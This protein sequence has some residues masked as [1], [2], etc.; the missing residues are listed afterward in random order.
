MTVSSTLQANVSLEEVF[1]GAR[2][3][4]CI[5]DRDGRLVYANPALERI[6]GYSPSELVE[7][8]HTYHP[9]GDTWED[10]GVVLA[11]SLC[12]SSSVFEKGGRSEVRRTHIT[13]KDGREIWIEAT[14]APVQDSDGNLQSILCFVRELGDADTRSAAATQP[15]ASGVSSGQPETLDAILARVEKEAILAALHR[16]EGQR[17]QAAKSMGISRSRLYRRMEAL[18]ISPREV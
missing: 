1:A 9:P 3:G 5:L 10:P 15:A 8:E 18:G 4:L 7:S 13:R 17:S 12:P 6:T 11:R 14:C 16:C 2:D